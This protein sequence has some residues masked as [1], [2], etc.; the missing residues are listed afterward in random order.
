MCAVHAVHAGRSGRIAKQAG[1]IAEESRAGNRTGKTH[2]KEGIKISSIQ[3][4]LNAS[5]QYT[6]P[7]EVHQLYINFIIVL[8]FP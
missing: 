1:Q 7:S 2:V 3:R 4:K 8:Q 6:R 5:K